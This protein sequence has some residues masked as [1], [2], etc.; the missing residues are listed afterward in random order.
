MEG[1][2][3]GGTAR[4]SYPA[5]PDAETQAAVAASSP[6]L[7]LTLKRKRPLVP[8]RPWEAIKAT[9]EINHVIHGN[10]RSVNRFIGRYPE[11]SIGAS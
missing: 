5:R 11:L 3:H 10:L 8:V 7:P 9:N 6:I 2:L 1:G 4:G